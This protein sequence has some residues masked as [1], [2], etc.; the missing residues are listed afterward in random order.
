MDGRSR[1][2]EDSPA[3][4][5]HLSIIQSVIARMASGSHSCKIWCVTITA[6]ILVLGGRM[7]K[8][9]HV[10]IAYFPVVLFLGLDMY[11]LALERRFRGAYNTFLR[12]LRSGD[13]VAADL[14]EVVPGGSPVKQWF[15]T[16]S[17]VSIWP[18]YPV[19]AGVVTFAWWLAG[20]YFAYSAATIIL[21][22]TG[23]FV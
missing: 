20:G 6:A 11:Y 8:L 7:D 3:V 12:R 4:Q 18:F 9:D 1:F 15:A 21:N 10:W 2:D 19:L 14:Y 5:T 16:L 17:S 13:I 23:S 22:K